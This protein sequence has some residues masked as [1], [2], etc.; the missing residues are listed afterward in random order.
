MTRRNQKRSHTELQSKLVD[1]RTSPLQKYLRFAAGP[2]GIA[3]F[4][5]YEVCMLLM[6][7]MP[8]APGYSLRKLFYPAMF[9]ACGKGV[10]FGRNITIR[11][12]SKITLGNH[13][14]IDDNCMLD[15]KGDD[16]HMRVG[17][18]CVISRNNIL[19]CKGGSIEVGDGTNIAQNSLVHAEQDSDVRLGANVIVGAYTYF[20]GGGNHRYERR[21]VPMMQQINRSLGG[22]VVEDDVWFGAR[23]TILDGVTIEKGAILAAGAVVR[24]NVPSYEIHAGV[25]ARKIKDRP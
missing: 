16:N 14:V 15:A 24:R 21:D 18:S 7:W 1:P 11:H 20:V 22:I 6:S 2:V 5:Y 3:R 23:V 12:A 10:T 13:V 8:G 17:N 19:S 25:P 4:A 9:A